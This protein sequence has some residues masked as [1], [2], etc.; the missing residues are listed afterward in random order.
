M[1][2]V[3]VLW[4]LGKGTY[5]NYRRA[6]AAVIRF[7][8]QLDS[9]DYDGIYGEASDEFRRAGSRPDLVTFLTAVHQKLGS[10]GNMKAVGFHVNW[11]NGRLFVDQV[12]RTQ[13]ARGQAQ[14]GFIWVMQQDQPRLVTYHIDSPDLH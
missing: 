5:H 6:S 14:E 3:I 11:Q 2:A 1:V 13:F 8:S 9:E 12:Y 4:S 7:H 10:P